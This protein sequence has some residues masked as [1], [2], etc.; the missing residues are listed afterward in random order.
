MCFIL[1]VALCTFSAGGYAFGQEPF[2]QEPGEVLFKKFDEIH[3]FSSPDLHARLDNVAISFQPNSS[4]GLLYLIAYSGPRAC[5]GDADRLNL[6]AKTYLA[7]RGVDSRR[8]VLID[9]GFLDMAVLDVWMLPSHVSPPEPMPNIDRT[10]VH[11]KNCTKRSSIRR[12]R[13]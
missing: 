8:V 10:Q 11:L 9:G 3:A 4:D 2:S 13:A 1:F 5:V 7:K 12:R 6:R